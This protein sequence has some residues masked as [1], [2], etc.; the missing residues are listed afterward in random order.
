MK[1]KNHVKVLSPELSIPEI[2][3]E[4]RSRREGKKPAYNFFEAK[5]KTLKKKTK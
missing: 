5:R 4:L 1:E 2:K 3:K